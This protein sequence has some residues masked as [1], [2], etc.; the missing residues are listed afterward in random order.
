MR[1]KS[2]YRLA[3]DS[4]MAA[5]YIALS[6][7][8][9]HVGPNLILSPASLPI[10]LVSL[11]YAPLDALL[12]SCVG[13]LLKQMISYGPSPTTVLWILPVML[14]SLI[15][16]LTASIYRHKGSYLEN[17]KVAYFVTLVVSFLVTTLANTGVIILDSRLMGYPDGLTWILTLTRFLSS[18]LT[19]LLLA[20]LSLP[21]L[22]VVKKINIGREPAITR[23][24]RLTKNLL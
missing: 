23:E 16:S 22:H 17:H 8:S 24:F 1:N 21:I 2:V 10:I 13:E 5:L 14:K 18:L 7:L 20:L 3:V 4:M 12:V 19:S 11:L 15:I 6:M 9:I